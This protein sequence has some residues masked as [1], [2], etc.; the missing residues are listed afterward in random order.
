MKETL[1]FSDPRDALNFQIG[2]PVR[3]PTAEARFSDVVSMVQGG[4]LSKEEGVRLLDRRP[5]I[6]DRAH[7]AMIRHL[8]WLFPRVVV[9]RVD[10][11][12]GIVELQQQRWSWSRWRWVEGDRG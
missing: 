12:A 11:D 10:V 6:A 7:E 9:S 3:R 1:R 4:F 8:P 5:S 2:A